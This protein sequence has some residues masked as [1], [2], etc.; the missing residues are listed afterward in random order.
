MSRPKYVE[1][2]QQQRNN[3]VGTK[4][5][6][7]PKVPV[8]HSMIPLSIGGIVASYLD[9]AE[10]KICVM[11]QND[12]IDITFDIRKYAAATGWI[13]VFKYKLPDPLAIFCGSTRLLLEAATEHNQLEI[14]EFICSLNNSDLGCLGY[15]DCINIAM[16]HEYVE[17]LALLIKY[18]PKYWNGQ[19]F[20]D[21]HCRGLTYV[22]TEAIIQGKIKIVKYLL[23]EYR[24]TQDGYNMLQIMA[25]RS[26]S[27][28]RSSIFKAIMDE[29]NSERYGDIDYQLPAEFR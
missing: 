29:Y 20:I 15:C 26:N 19:M 16:E 10:Q 12:K 21:N 23:L 6:W 14:M 24:F 22:M 1:Y 2:K 13:D 5:K 9:E 18:A 7:V 4:Y 25:C 27:K 11:V 28:E 3:K 17:A 8:A